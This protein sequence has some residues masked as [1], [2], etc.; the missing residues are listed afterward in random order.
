V[1]STLYFRMCPFLSF[2][3]LFKLIAKVMEDKYNSTMDLNS[4]FGIK[5]KLA[6]K[7]NI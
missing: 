7:A 2:M 5:V 6:I 1:A 4:S 3:L